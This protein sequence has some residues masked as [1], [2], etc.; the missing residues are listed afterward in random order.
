MTNQF[1]YKYKLP[2]QKS[3][4]IIWRYRSMERAVKRLY[5]RKLNTVEMLKYA[6]ANIEKKN[7]KSHAH[8][9]S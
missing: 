1:D 3:G 9:Q 2:E 7:Y 4:F 5:K 6:E 8:S